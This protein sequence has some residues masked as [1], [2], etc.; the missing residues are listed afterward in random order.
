MYLHGKTFRALYLA[1]D[2]KAA[3]AWY[4]KAAAQGV[5]YSDATF[6]FE[7]GVFYANGITV[8]Q[9]FKAAAEWFAK[10]SAIHFVRQGHADAEFHLG[11]AYANGRGVVRDAAAAAAWYAKAASSWLKKAAPCLREMNGSCPSCC[12]KRILCGGFLCDAASTAAWLKRE[13]A[14]HDVYNLGLNLNYGVVTSISWVAAA[15]VAN[16]AARGLVTLTAAELWPPRRTPTALQRLGLV[17]SFH[18]VGPSLT[19]FAL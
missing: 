4:T 16:A 13:A 7:L 12:A 2:V 3:A 10:A 1:Q 14:A 8:A 15:W 6:E 19:G 9:D 18:G 5:Y 17:M 11:V